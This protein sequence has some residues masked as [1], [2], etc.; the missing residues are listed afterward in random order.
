ME[1]K[2][3]DALLKSVGFFADRLTDN[4]AIGICVILFVIGIL[5]A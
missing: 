1:K 4:Q 3:D 5:L 2:Y